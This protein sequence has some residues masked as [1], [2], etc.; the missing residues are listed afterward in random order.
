MDRFCNSYSAKPHFYASFLFTGTAIILNHEERRKVLLV[1]HVLPTSGH[2]GKSTMC[3]KDKGTFYV[4]RN[5]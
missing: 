2:M 3:T 5:D 1:Y 4:A